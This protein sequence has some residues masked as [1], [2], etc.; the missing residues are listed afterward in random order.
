MHHGC[1]CWRQRRQGG[2]SRVVA[3]VAKLSVGREEYYTR[4]LATDHEQYPVRP[5]RVTGPLVR[6]RRRLPGAAR[7][8][9]GRGLPAG[10]RG[11]PPHHR[12]APRPPH[13]RATP[14][15]PSTWSCGPPRASR[16]WGWR[17]AVNWRRRCGPWPDR[18]AVMRPPSVM[19]RPETNDGAGRSGVCAGQTACG[20]RDRVRTCDLVVVSDTRYHCATRP[21][22][23]R[24]SAPTS[25][26]GVDQCNAP[27][28][29]LRLRPRN[30]ATTSSP[31]R[32]VTS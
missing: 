27:G 4:E 10:I 8:S 30:S 15:P 5:R 21:C 31:R 11:P 28:G 24:S 2:S 22:C 26:L 14:C 7:R 29:R 6:R 13:G 18:S 32:T 3:D 12:R 20:G 9:I 19:R 17:K 23:F 25:E 1:V 16:S